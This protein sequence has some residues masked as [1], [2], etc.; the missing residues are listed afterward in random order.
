[1]VAPQQVPKIQVQWSL[2]AASL[3]V[4]CPMPP[5]PNTEST[6]ILVIQFESSMERGWR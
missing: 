3:H 2:P 6:G 1:M 5:T 4:P